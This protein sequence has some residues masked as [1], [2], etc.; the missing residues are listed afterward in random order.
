MKILYKLYKRRSPCCNER[1][2]RTL[3]YYKH[4]G[5]VYERF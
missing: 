4:K 5:K 1:V 3:K 2:L